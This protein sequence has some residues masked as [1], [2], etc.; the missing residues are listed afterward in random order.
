MKS[1]DKIGLVEMENVSMLFL[2]GIKAKLFARPGPY[3]LSL[4]L[5]A[6]PNWVW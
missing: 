3:A 4:D 1:V 6:T 5:S 2:T